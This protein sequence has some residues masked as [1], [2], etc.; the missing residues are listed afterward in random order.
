[1]EIAD[2]TSDVF[3]PLKVSVQ[4]GVKLFVLLGCCCAAENYNNTHTACFGAIA[5][6]DSSTVRVS[7]SC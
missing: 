2:R 5:S 7:R 3:T 1:M 4:H 6:P